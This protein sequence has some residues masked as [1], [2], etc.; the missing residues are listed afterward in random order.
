MDTVIRV[1]TLHEVV[2]ISRCANNLEINM[3]LIMEKLM[4]KHGS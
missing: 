4:S 2:W 1:Q 3:N